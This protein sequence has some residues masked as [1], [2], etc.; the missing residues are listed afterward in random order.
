MGILDSVKGIFGIGLNYRTELQAVVDQY[1][2]FKNLQWAYGGFTDER[3]GITSR[4]YTSFNY[5]VLF[6]NNEM[7]IIPFSDKGNKISVGEPLI[8]ERSNLQEITYSKTMQLFYAKFNNGQEVRFQ[9][10]PF[11]I[12]I[13]MTGS[14]NIKQKEQYDQYKNF[15]IPF[16][17]SFNF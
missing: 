12:K 1:P 10:A 13:P 5:I 2:N 7:H 9:V 4:T 6:G 17:D 16:V 11:S 8:V 14:I 3:Q 15:I